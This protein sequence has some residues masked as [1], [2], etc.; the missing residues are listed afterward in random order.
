MKRL[1]LLSLL[2]LL[3]W[4]CQTWAEEPQGHLALYHV[5]VYEAAEFPV[6]PPPVGDKIK[7]R[8]TKRDKVNAPQTPQGS[9]AEGLELGYYI[10]LV[11]FAVGLVIFPIGV[12]LGLAWLWWLGIGFWLIHY[13]VLAIVTQ[14][15]KDLGRRMGNLKRL[16]GCFIALLL[17]FEALLFIGLLI[18]FIVVGLASGVSGLWIPALVV[19][20]IGLGVLT[21]FGLKDS[22]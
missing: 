5:G 15:L 3:L 18:E 2:S 16:G 8:K 4:P 17:I 12:G 10:S 21:Y 11:L 22:M 9:Q 20:I 13:V 1:L 6:Q 19:L 14:T 7:K